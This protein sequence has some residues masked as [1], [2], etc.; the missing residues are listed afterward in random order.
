M[1]EFLFVGRIMENL[2]IENS[3]NSLEKLLKNTTQ[4]VLGYGPV[5]E[6][7]NLPNDM[8]RLYQFTVIA[9]TIEEAKEY[10]NSIGVS[11]ILDSYW[12]KPNDEIA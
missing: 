9:N 1:I 7:T 2:D 5:F 12:F 11:S 10:I 6:N 4:K 8:K 3:Y